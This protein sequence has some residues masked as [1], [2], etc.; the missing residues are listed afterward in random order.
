MKPRRRLREEAGFSILES[1][2][3]LALVFA[4]LVG[5]LGALTAGA[6]GVVTG[7]QRSAALA[8]ANEVLEGARGRDYGDI[9][10]DFDSDPTLTTDPLIT[11]AA[12]NFMFTG[13]T[14]AEPLA[15]SAVDAGATGGTVNNPLWPFSPHKFTSKR[16]QT[17][18][19]TEVYV[20]TVTPASGDSYKRIT[21]KVS[22]S[23]AQYVTAARSVMLSTFLFNAGTPPD[24]KLVG[25]GEADAGSFAV[26]GTVIGIDLSQLSLVFPYVSG[27]VDSGFVRSA[28]GLARTG[29]NELELLSG[30]MTG[31]SL[32]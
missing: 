11:G 29:T 8:M 4:V 23:P 22:W 26:T 17:T 24:P 10:H 12:P 28:K 5:L 2:I 6:R 16:E 21:T 20:S 32:L 18:F 13:V 7:R 9:G 31:C 25:T 19:T 14:P 15:T 27:G 3:A 1:T 30:T